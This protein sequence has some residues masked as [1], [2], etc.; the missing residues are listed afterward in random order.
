[1]KGRSHDGLTAKGLLYSTVQIARLP[2]GKFSALQEVFSHSSTCKCCTKKELQSLIGWLCH[3]CMVVWLGCTF[4]HQM[5]DLL[6]SFHNDYYPRTPPR[7]GQWN[8]ISFFP[9]LSL[10]LTFVSVLMCL[11]LLVLVLLWTMNSSMVSALLFNFHCPLLTGNFFLL[12]WRLMS[13]VLVGLAG[14]SCFMLI[15]KL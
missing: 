10:C 15:T 3:A 11:G 8:R 5:I 1:M 12:F 2:A 4:L 7:F 13:G 6:S 9:P 14:V